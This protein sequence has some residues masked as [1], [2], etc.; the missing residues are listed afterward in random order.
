MLQAC[1][2]TDKYKKNGRKTIRIGL[3]SITFANQTNKP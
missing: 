1:N 3:I 2:F